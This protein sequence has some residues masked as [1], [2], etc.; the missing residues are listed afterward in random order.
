M[1]TSHDWAQVRLVWAYKP[2]TDVQRGQ[3]GK[4]AGGAEPEMSQEEE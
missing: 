3:A 1:A 2:N 4:E